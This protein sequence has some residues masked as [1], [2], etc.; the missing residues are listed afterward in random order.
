MKELAINVFNVYQI[1]KLAL[2]INVMNVL[3]DYFVKDRIVHAQMGI[4]KIL[5]KLNANNV[6]LY[7]K[8]V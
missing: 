8:H 5:D 3:M 4:L 6:L 2:I 1:V 7:A